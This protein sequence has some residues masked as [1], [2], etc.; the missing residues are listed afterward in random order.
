MHWLITLSGLALATLSQHA[1]LAATTLRTAAQMDSEPKFVAAE[2]YGEPVVEGLCVDIF[3]AIEKID[4]GLVFSGDQ[5]W[6]P[7][8]RID[9]NLHS[10]L[11]DVACGM[12]RTEHRIKDQQ[13]LQPALFSL[14][15]MLL[16]RAGD[17][18]AV[19]DWHDVVGLGSDNVVLSIYGTGPSRQLSSLPAL[20][21]DAGSSTVQQNIHKLLAGRGRFFYYR[22]PAAHPVIRDYLARGQIRVLPAVML[23]APAYLMIG[24]HVAPAITRRIEAALWKLS[25]GGQLAALA[26]QWSVTPAVSPGQ[27]PLS[28][29]PGHRDR[30]PRRRSATMAESTDL[31]KERNDGCES[32]QD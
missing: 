4:A 14:R 6:S 24:R 10:G 5:N 27:P 13:L 32:N 9:A 23:E 15:Y 30:Q 18:V 3:H 26:R 22:Q 29:H 21:V 11:L 25:G 19:D 28:G 12:I 7:S 31:A 8:A 1:A 20:R 2:Y 17:V 16:A